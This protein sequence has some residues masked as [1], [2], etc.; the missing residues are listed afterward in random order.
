[1][2]LRYQFLGCGSWAGSC[3]DDMKPVHEVCLDGFWIGKYEV[4]Q[5]QWKRVMGSNPSHFKKGDNYPVEKVSWKN[6]KKFI[7]KLNSMK[8]G[9]FRLRLPTEAEW[10]YAAR[11]GGKAEQYAGGND[12]DRVAW[13]RNNG[14]RTH[15]AGTKAPNG[16][17]IYDMSGN[18]WEWCED[19]YSDTAYSKHQRN[20]PIYMGKG[21]DRVIRGG[22]WFY[23][24]GWCRS[25]LRV[26]NTPRYRCDY[27]GFR[28]ARN[29]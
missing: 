1:V 8:D 18:V 29:E 12:V 23:G 7:G 10:E 28:L 19:I 20:N 2:A 27:L 3:H 4:T 11:S 17:G 21:S 24:Y 13:H 5:G 14:Y 9:K 15:P 6:A 25:G 22:C 16:L 26:R